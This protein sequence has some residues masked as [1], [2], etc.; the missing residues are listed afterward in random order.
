MNR[1]YTSIAAILMFLSSG[2]SFAAQGAPYNQGM[3]R[4]IVVDY[5][6]G[7]LAQK[8]YGQDGMAAVATHKKMLEDQKKFIQGSYAP[9]LLKFISSGL[10]LISLVG[11]TIASRAAGGSYELLNKPENLVGLSYPDFLK[12]AYGFDQGKI[13]GVR[14]LATE[15]YVKSTPTQH[16]QIFDVGIKAPWIFGG[17]LITGGLARYLWNKAAS[18]A[19]ELKRLDAA[20]KLDDDILSFLDLKTYEFQ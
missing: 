8:S 12:V 19:D 17:S 4:N 10:Y 18:Y 11:T 16:Q 20:I 1:K 9:A 6:N 5:Q 3:Y 14:M 7:V 15:E 13:S 2:L